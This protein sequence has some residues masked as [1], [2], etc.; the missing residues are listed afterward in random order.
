MKTCP[1]CKT[2]EEWAF[3]CSP[4]IVCLNCRYYYMAKKEQREYEKIYDPIEK[5]MH[6]NIKYN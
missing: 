2:S 6:E 4:R 5:K 1:Y 3:A